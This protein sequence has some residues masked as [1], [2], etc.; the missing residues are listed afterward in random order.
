MIL[1]P[2]LRAPRSVV[3]TLLS[4]VLFGAGCG[5]PSGGPEYTELELSAD[6]AAG[7]ELGDACTSLPVLPGGTLEHDYALAPGLTTHVFATRDSISVTLH[8]T[9]ADS[10]SERTFSQALLY[11]GY[12]ESLPITMLDGTTYTLHFTSPCLTAPAPR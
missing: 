9:V 8:G 10:T 1:P 5:A 3:P 11:A 12:A 7:A 4:A 6:S 2:R